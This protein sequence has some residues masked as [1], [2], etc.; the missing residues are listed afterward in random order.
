MLRTAAAFVYKDEKKGGSLDAVAED[1][2]RIYAEALAIDGSSAEARHEKQAEYLDREAAK[3]L[4]PRF[5]GL[6]DYM[7]AAGYYTMMNKSWD[8]RIVEMQEVDPLKARPTRRIIP[9]EL[10][11]DVISAK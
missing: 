6:R 8:N 4:L 9:A 1:M 7:Q 10:S 11:N 5:E 3:I 2:E